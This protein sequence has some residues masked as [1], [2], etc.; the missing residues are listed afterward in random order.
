[1]LFL[2]S[3]II[4]QNLGALGLSLSYIIS[5]GINTVIFVPFYIS[6]KVIPLDLLISKEVIVIWVVLIIQ[7]TTSLM[8]INIWIRLLTLILSIGILIFVFKRIIKN[9][10]KKI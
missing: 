1:M 6:R 5:Y 8:N 9:N 10:K 3:I 2:I 7:T 4:F